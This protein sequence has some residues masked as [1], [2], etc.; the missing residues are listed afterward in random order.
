MARS[1]CRVRGAAEGAADPEGHRRSTAATAETLMR[2]LKAFR[3]AR[4]APAPAE[5]VAQI[6]AVR[7]FPIEAALVALLLITAAA[8]GYEDAILDRQLILSRANTN[9]FTP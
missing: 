7:K 2:V 3:Q 1:K 8:I 6:P 5:A 4:Q 9:A